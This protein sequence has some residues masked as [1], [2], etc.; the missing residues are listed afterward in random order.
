MKLDYFLYMAESEGLNEIVTTRRTKIN[1][2]INDFIAAA[3]NGYDINNID[4]QNF[5]FNKYNFENLTTKES[6]YIVQAV[7]KRI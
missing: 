5:I 3:K 6:Q 7:Q 2:I 1:A 4:F